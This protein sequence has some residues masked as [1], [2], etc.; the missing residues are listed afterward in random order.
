MGQMQRFDG[1]PHS[2]A[3]CVSD[4]DAYR[5]KI[6]VVSPYRSS[7]WASITLVDA[8]PNLHNWVVRCISRQFFL[9]SILL[10]P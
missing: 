2:M 9:I 6:G 3:E 5:E 1:K 8:N 10:E 4:P 7:D